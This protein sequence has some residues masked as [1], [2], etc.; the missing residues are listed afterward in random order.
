MKNM[1]NNVTTINSLCYMGK[2]DLYIQDKGKDIHLATLNKGEAGI[3]ELFTRACLGYPTEKYRPYQ[4]DLL[5]GN[6]SMLIQPVQLRASTF[7]TIPD[8]TYAGWEYPI[9]DGLILTSN[10]LE[11]QEGVAQIKLQSSEGINLAS[12]DIYITKGSTNH[13]TLPTLHLTKNN[14]IL[15]RW[16]MYLS[17]KVEESNG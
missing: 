15:I 2:V 9:F 1:M 10:L 14:N 11:I 3:A 16:S 7:D 4:I 13:E 17:N 6:T 8:G 12:I 5:S